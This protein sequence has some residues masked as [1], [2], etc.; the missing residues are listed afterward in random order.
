MKQPKAPRE[1]AGQIA[2]RTAEEQRVAAAEAKAHGQQLTALG[3][4][5]RRRT[6]QVRRA[7]GARTT[8]NSGLGGLG[9][10]AGVGET[11]GGAGA[12]GGGGGGF[13]FGEGAAGGRGFGDYMDYA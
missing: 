7:Y 2:A 11:S 1:T 4:D 5:A 8:L 6:T 9:G 12:S 13:G 3:R 10:M